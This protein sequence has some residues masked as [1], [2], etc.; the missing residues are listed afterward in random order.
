MVERAVP[1]NGSRMTVQSRRSVLRSVWAPA[2]LFLVA[3]AALLALHRYNLW[4][5][6][7]GWVI[8]DEGHQVYQPLRWLAGQWPYRDFATDNYPPGSIWL[9]ALLFDLF[10]VK[11]SVMRVFLAGVGA[12]IAAM[13][14]VVARKIMPAGPALIAYLLSLTWNV[15]NLN[16]GYPSWYCTLLGLI[17]LPVILRYTR[18]GKAHWLVVAGVLAGLSLALKTTQ[19]AFQWIGLASFLAWRSMAGRTGV[20][21]VRRLLT[22]ESGFLVVTLILAGVLLRSFPTPVNLLVFGAPFLLVSV[23]VVM[24][25]PAHEPTAASRPFLLEL[26]WLGLGLGLVT[27]AWVWLTVAGVGW[28]LF[29]DGTFLAPLRHSDYMYAWIRP[30]TSN[31]WLLL[32]WALGGGLWLL[33]SKRLRPAGVLAWGALGV[34]LLFLPIPF[35]ASPREWLRSGFQTWREMRFYLA[36][37]VSLVIWVWLWRG[38]VERAH[39]PA[40]VLLLM[41][42]AWNFMQVY[43]FADSNHLLWAI[44]PVFIGLA[45]I[46]NRLWKVSTLKMAGRAAGWAPAPCD[47]RRAGDVYCLA[48]LSGD[49]PFL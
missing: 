1:G 41:Y 29:I 27:L 10:G 24:G 35:S 45:Y 48:G 11:L 34:V 39:R 47:R 9:H 22:W 36:L 46:V 16:M 28:D 6:V 25:R 44:Q 31:G 17:A 32:I 49:R 37:L 18:T 8:S 20:S 13:V 12:G 33:R 42:S 5:M 30:P 2:I 43:P 19:G 15:L 26:V 23:A 40:L 38:R 7:E 3:L 14:F 4:D 21:G